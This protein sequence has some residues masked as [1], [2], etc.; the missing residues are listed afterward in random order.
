MQAARLSKSSGGT[1]APT[2]AKWQPGYRVAWRYADDRFAVADW[3]CDGARGIAPPADE[4]TRHFEINLHRRGWHIRSLA[5]RRYFIDPLHHSLWPAQSGFRLSNNTAHPQA[6]TLL[7]VSRELLEEA[8]GTIAGTG[9]ATMRRLRG[10]PAHWRS[11]A[12]TVCHARLLATRSEDRLAIE[13]NSLALIRQVVA[14]AAGSAVA[15]VRSQSARRV[16]VVDRARSY[17]LNRYRESL[18][19][20]SIAAASGV[21]PSTLCENFPCIVGVPVWRYVQRLRLQDAA[22]A[23][24]EGA[25]DL[26]RLALDLGFSSH[27]HFAQA[28]RAHFGQAP[29]HFRRDL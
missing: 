17:I 28:F 8:L 26:S 9:I 10:R 27:S 1:P 7:F 21:A 5:R 15:G 4:F 13:E 23:L 2:T 3:S 14:E 29:S 25:T 22:L 18:S 12:L 20:S 16:A 19:L 6:A 11:S 24:G